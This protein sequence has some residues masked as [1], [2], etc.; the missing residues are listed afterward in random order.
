M[1][2]HPIAKLRE[3]SHCELTIK[4]IQELQI[5]VLL[6]IGRGLLSLVI[7]HRVKR[8]QTQV[9][10]LIEIKE[11]RVGEKRQFRIEAER[12]LLLLLLLHSLVVRRGD[13]VQVLE[14]LGEVGG[15]TAVEFGHGGM[16]G[17]GKEASR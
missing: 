11:F 16:V 7:V 13:R 14:V 12:L 17:R 4:E 1:Q 3:K 5:R 9:S 8:R 2:D 10:Q 15:A 6:H